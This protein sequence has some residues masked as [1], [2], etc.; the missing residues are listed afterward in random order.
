M[1]TQ[2]ILFQQFDYNPETGLF[3]RKKKTSNNA[4][5]T[6][7]SGWDNKSGYIK[8]CINNKQQFAHRMAWL[9]VYGELPDKDVDHINGNRS[10]NRICNLRITNRSENMQNTEK[11]KTNTSGF[12]GVTW[13]KKEKKWLAQITKNY[14][15]FNIGVF[16]TAEQ[17][18]AAYCQAA[19][20]V[21]THNRVIDYV[22]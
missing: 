12:K 4:C 3:F 16:E 21:H 10:D 15:H 7:P 1:I 13:L 14:Q 17:A 11:F 9:Y 20:E 2:E 19:K 8:L 6:K 22:S 18:Y 5:V